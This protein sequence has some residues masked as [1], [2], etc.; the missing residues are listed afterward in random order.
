MYLSTYLSERL[1]FFLLGN[2]VP[3][4]ITRSS[5]HYG[6]IILL[7]PLGF[8]VILCSGNNFLLQFD[9]FTVMSSSSWGG[10]SPFFT[11]AA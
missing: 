7:L 8:D 4:I 9:I 2:S 11:I 1:K 6:E 10:V 5:I 3:L